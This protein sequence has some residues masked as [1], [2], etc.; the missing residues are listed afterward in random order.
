LRDPLYTA[1]AW[2]TIDQ[3]SNGRTIF[4]V[5]GGNTVEPGVRREFAVLGLEPGRRMARLEEALEAVRDLWTTGRVSLHG[6]HFDYDDVAFHSGTEVAPLAPQ[7]RPPPIW[8]VSNP[9]V[10]GSASEERVRRNLRRAADRIVRLA[11]GWLT[12][13][14]ASHPEEVE[15]QL[16]A[17]GAAA[18]E[19]ATRPDRFTVAYQVTVALADS[20]EDAAD[21]FGRFIAAYYPEFG[22][23]VDPR[24]WGPLGSPVD[25]I[26]WFLRFADAGVDHFLVRFASVDEHAVMRRFV[27]DVVPALR[28][29]DRRHI[30][31]WP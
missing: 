5:S 9:R 19:H 14:R 1:M 25:V 13:C 24:D 8:L 6:E 16:A 30:Q 2:S 3:L 12:C 21:Y 17:I 4:G 10:G 31:P 11:D 26:R 29:D 20:E 27:A 7:Q 15:E 23:Q 22:S 18:V 28:S